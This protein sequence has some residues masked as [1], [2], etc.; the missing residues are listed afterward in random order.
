MIYIYIYV[1]IHNKLWNKE[2][3]KNIYIYTY[4]NI[5]TCPP[6]RRIF[7]PPTFVA[8]SAF[9]H[10]KI[11]ILHKTNMGWKKCSCFAF[12]NPYKSLCLKRDRWRKCC[13]PL[14]CLGH[15]RAHGH[16]CLFEQVLMAV[17]PAP[18]SKITRCDVKVDDRWWLCGHEREYPTPTTNLTFVGR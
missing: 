12:D 10:K 6:C 5:Y 14:C 4:C 16:P 15:Q 1:Y 8:K 9:R 7:H 3:N 11:Q 2:I 13:F 18:S 17:F